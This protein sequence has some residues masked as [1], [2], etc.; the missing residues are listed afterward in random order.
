M[1]RARKIRR[2][3]VRV[4]METRGMSGLAC[5]RHGRILIREDRRGV[6]RFSRN[7]IE[8][9]KGFLRPELRQAIGDD[10]AHR[11]TERGYLFAIE[12]ERAPT[13]VLRIARRS[14]KMLEH[15]QP[16]AGLQVMHQRL[17]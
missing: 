17:E 15:Q 11:Q 4:M 12:I 1:P 16:P 8:N 14:R 7:L 13:H 2:S 10:L 5:W 9:K 6:R 3:L